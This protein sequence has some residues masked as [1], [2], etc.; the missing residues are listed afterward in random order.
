MLRKLVFLIALVTCTPLLA[1]TG[2]VE[3][4]ILALEEQ[5]RLAASK[6]DP[7]FL[8]QYATDDYLVIAPDG[9]IMTKKQ[10]LQ[11]M[12]SGDIRYQSLDFIN[13]PKVRIYGGNTAIVNGEA[14]AVLT[15]FG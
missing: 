14:S 11:A 15:N 13:T 1:Q 4:Q 7:S 10:A 5:S 3:Q 12:I 6:N 8:K 2:T 9:S